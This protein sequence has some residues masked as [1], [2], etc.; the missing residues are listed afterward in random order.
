ME[1]HLLSII[2]EMNLGEKWPFEDTLDRVSFIFVF[3]CFFIGSQ[4]TKFNLNVQLIVIMQGALFKCLMT[5]HDE[6]P[7]FE[8]KVTLARQLR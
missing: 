2:N 7:T 6:E 8:E 4:K 5:V 1:K 3:F